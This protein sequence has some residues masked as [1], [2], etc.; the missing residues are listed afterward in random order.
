MKKV[1]HFLR[2]THIICGQKGKAH[3]SQSIAT[4]TCK[5]CAKMLKADTKPVKEAIPVPEGTDDWRWPLSFEKLQDEM[6]K[7]RIVLY[8]YYDNGYCRKVTW[9]PYN[10]QLEVRCED[11]SW[12]FPMKNIS[13]ALDKYNDPKK[14][15]KA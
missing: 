9:F 10:D 8:N 4:V 13:Q 6:S 11:S 15:V 14:Y 2:N 7:R 12:K 3:W 5:R 1:T